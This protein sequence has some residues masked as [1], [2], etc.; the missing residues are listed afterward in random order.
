M[1]SPK[2]E[3]VKRAA[4]I[5]AIKHPAGYNKNQLTE[6]SKEVFGGYGESITKPATIKPLKTME[7]VDNMGNAM[8]FIDGHYPAGMS[9]CFVVGINGGCGYSCPVFNNKECDELGDFT[10]EEYRASDDYDED[11]AWYYWDCI[12]DGEQSDSEAEK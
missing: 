3:L 5:A 11:V 2:A 9:G 1:F 6:A 12:N 10:V 4:G 7:D 8:A